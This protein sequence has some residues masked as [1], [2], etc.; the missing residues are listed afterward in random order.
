MV[1][2]FPGGVIAK[3]T[4]SNKAKDCICGRKNSHG[5]IDRNTAK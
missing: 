1:E 5:K 2:A 3:F 4:K